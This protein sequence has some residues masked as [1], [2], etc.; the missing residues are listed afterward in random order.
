LGYVPQEIFLTDTSIAENVALGV[1]KSEIDMAAVERSARMAQVHDFVVEELSDAYDTVVGE[2]GVRLSG[3]QRQRIGIARA[4]Y[5]DPEV[6][7]LDEATS[8][9]DT[10]TEKAVMEAVDAISK[11]RTVI[12]IAHRLSTVRRC[13]QIVLLSQGEIEA[14]GPYE[15]LRESSAHFKRL[16]TS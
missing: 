14:V 12:I 7:V 10:L 5:H 2:R 6:L 4:L 8:A 3:G 11:S 13:N 9:L 16:S 15:E 1:P